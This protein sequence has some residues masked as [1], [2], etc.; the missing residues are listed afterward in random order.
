MMALRQTKSTDLWDVLLFP[1]PPDRC[2][3]GGSPRLPGLA[4]T[5]LTAPEAVGPQCAQLGRSGA[6]ATLGPHLVRG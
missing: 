5:R 3:A 1:C 6:D 4:S 2:K